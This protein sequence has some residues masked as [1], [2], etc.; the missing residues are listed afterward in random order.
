MSAASASKTGKEKDE[1]IVKSG[2]CLSEF[3]FGN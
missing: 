2:C 1:S 3:F